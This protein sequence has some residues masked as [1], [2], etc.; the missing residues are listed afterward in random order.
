MWKCLL[1]KFIAG[2]S[3]CQE[4]EKLNVL[5]ISIKETRTSMNDPIHIHLCASQRTKFCLYSM[6][7]WIIIIFLLNVTYLTFL[8]LP[9]YLASHCHHGIQTHS[10]YASQTPAFAI[11]HTSCL[12]LLLYLSLSFSW[13][14]NLLVSHST[15]ISLSVEG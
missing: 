4:A 6:R 9:P 8:S 13:S 11:D 2:F 10:A 7:F 12:C 14:L 1:S 3:C 15:F 5:H